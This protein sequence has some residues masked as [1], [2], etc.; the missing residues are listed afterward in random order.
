[1][2]ITPRLISLATEEGTPFLPEDQGESSN[3]QDSAG[4]DDT[5]P[6]PDL[7]NVETSASMARI[8][9]VIKITTYCS[10]T[11][12]VVC[13]VLLLA[14]FFTTILSPYSRYSW[15]ADY[16]MGIIAKLGI[17]VRVLLPL[18]TSSLL[19]PICTKSHLFCILSLPGSAHTAPPILI[20]K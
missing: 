11:S 1:M 7:E 14:A 2:A 17:C 13:L 8:F 9:S 4:H 6:S 16:V 12:S 18:R 20:P 5:L 10:L 19:L 15:E 3:H